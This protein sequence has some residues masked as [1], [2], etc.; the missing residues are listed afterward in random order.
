M[1]ETITFLKA[2][3]DSFDDRERDDV[4]ADS[5]DFI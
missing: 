2:S 1:W 5:M 4:L 3:P